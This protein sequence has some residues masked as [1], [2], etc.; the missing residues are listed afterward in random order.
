MINRHKTTIKSSKNNQILDLTRKK[1]TPRM[2][3]DNPA[4]EVLIK[5]IATL[6]WGNNVKEEVF[7]RWAQG[8]L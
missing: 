6:L 2:M 3:A 8:L 7:N 4:D 5:E 1:D